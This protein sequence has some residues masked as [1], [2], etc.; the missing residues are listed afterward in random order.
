M[1]GTIT[2][3]KTPR[4][5][6]CHPDCKHPVCLAT[7]EK[8][9]P[10][11]HSVKML[12]DDQELT[13]RRGTPHAVGWDLRAS[14][15]TVIPAGT[16][17]LIPTG[18]RLEMPEW[19]EAQ[20]RPRSGLSL[21]GIDACFGSVDPDYRGVIGVTLCNNSGHDFVVERGDRIAQLV[22][23]SVLPTRLEQADELSP[24]ERGEG[25]FGSTGVK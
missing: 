11:P 23:S 16:R 19:M 10:L 15:R 4:T 7:V 13:P 1:S 18:I 12:A 5:K 17:K 8:H 20:V 6:P 24:T 9:M 22:F 21:K 14:A 25:G 3:D 2:I